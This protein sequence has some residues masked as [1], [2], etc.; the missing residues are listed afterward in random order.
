MSDSPEQVEINLSDADAVEADAVEKTA[1]PQ[2]TA[3]TT[4]TS[5]KASKAPETTAALPTERLAASGQGQRRA[6]HPMAMPAAVN[7]AFVDVALTAKADD[8]RPTLKVSGKSA[9][10]SQVAARASAPMTL[11]ASVESTANDA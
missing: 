2:H 3:E 4:E 11:P 7:D 1:A 9:V 5:S 6:S 8:A 10:M